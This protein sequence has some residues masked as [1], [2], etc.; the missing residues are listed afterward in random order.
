MRKQRVKFNGIARSYS[1]HDTPAGACEELINLRSESDGLKVVGNKRVILADKTFDKIIEHSTADFNNLIAVVGNK[2]IRVNRVSGE[3]TDIFT[4]QTANI[5][6]AVLNN[7][8][9]IN[10]LDAA[11]M[12][13]FQFKDSQYSL[14]FDRLPDMALLTRPDLVAEDTTY[15]ESSKYRNEQAE[16]VGLKAQEVKDALIAGIKEARSINNEYTEGYVL[17]CSSYTLYDGTETKMSPPYLIKLAGYNVTPFESYYISSGEQDLTAR[18]QVQKLFLALT[19][20]SNLT[21]YRDLIRGINIYCSNPV[22]YYKTTHDGITLKFQLPGHSV[23]ETTEIASNTFEAGMFESALMYRQYSIEINSP[24]EPKYQIRFGDEL[25]TGKTMPVDSSGWM[26][27]VGRPFVYNNRLHIYDY[28]RSLITE[29]GIYKLMSAGSSV[30]PTTTPAPQVERGAFAYYVKSTI[31]RYDAWV[32]YTATIIG[33]IYYDHVDGKWYTTADGTTLV[34]PGWYLVYYADTEQYSTIYAIRV[35]EIVQ[36]G[37][38]TVVTNAVTD[39]AE[40]QITA[41]GEVTSDG[42]SAV[43]ER[44]FVYATTPN[45]TTANSKVVVGSGVG[46]FSEAITGLTGGTAYHVRAYAANSVGTTYG[47]SAQFE[48]TASAG[49]PSVTTIGVAT[50]TQSEATV[51]G[52]VTNDNG[53]AVTERGFVYSTSNNPTTANTKVIVGSGEGAYYDVITGLSPSTAYFIRSYA[54]NSI[55]TSYGSV[56]QFSTAAIP[57]TTTAGP[58][59]FLKQLKWGTSIEGAMSGSLV[60]VYCYDDFAYLVTGAYFYSDAE[61]TTYSQDGYYVNPTAGWN[62][63]YTYYKVETGE[64]TEIGEYIFRWLDVYNYYSSNSV[65]D[66]IQGPNLTYN[67]YYEIA[68]AGS[69]GFLEKR[70]YYKGQ[71]SVSEYA[72]PGYYVKSDQVTFI[73]VGANGV[74]YVSVGGSITTTGSPTNTPQPPTTTPQPVDPTTTPAPGTTTPAPVTTTPAPVTTTPAPATTTPAPSRYEVQ[75]FGYDAASASSCFYSN[76]TGSFWT[77]GAGYPCYT[78]QSG[79]TLINDGYY[80]SEKNSGVEDSVIFEVINGEMPIV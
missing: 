2:I 52:E 13:V 61:T 74:A 33:Y 10:C 29:I 67:L 14:L 7:M 45:P 25:I 46:S 23:L 41:N 30:A 48:T 65:N 53:S 49:A 21:Q 73:Q 43:T 18:I 27:T 68:I 20:P 50:I 60:N 28:K 15:I 44:G 36:P 55:G 24:L 54:I 37:S 3:E 77:L 8:L 4:A 80:M 69:P 47:E 70:V 17:V 40:T 59:A 66:A 64:V 57:S 5:E 38:P 1:E 62:G 75:Y 32:N 12:V 6:L 71:S 35:D 79:S 78:T 42:G 9:I 31:S 51:S 34:S 56:I 72:D 58:V 19:L 22:S 11:S 63:R 26:T 39:I 16:L 76:L